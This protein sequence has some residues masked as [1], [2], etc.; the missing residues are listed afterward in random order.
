MLSCPLVCVNARWTDISTDSLS[1]LSLSTRRCS[2]IPVPCPLK[3]EVGTDRDE[4]H[5]NSEAKTQALIG[6]K[7]SYVRR[8]RQSSS[9]SS[10]VGH[11][12]PRKQQRLFCTV[13]K[14]ARFYEILLEVTQEVVD[15]VR[16]KRQ[17]EENMHAE[18]SQTGRQSLRARDAD[19]TF[20]Q[21]TSEA[22]RW[23]RALARE[24]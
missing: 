14:N 18:I 15:S 8:V 1:F 13:Q 22:T 24:R 5:W 19:S 20:V 12:V 23:N 6:R 17:H 16:K 9:R 4:S 3:N 21:E 2:K 7:K 11:C 10:N